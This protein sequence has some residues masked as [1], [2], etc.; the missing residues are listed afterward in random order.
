MAFSVDSLL[1]DAKVSLE[2]TAVDQ[3][4]AVVEDFGKQVGS[5]FGDLEKGI[6]SAKGGR[7]KSANSNPQRSWDA[8]SYAAH[9]AGGTD[10]RPKLKFLFKVEFIFNAEALKMINKID[11]LFVQKSKE[12]TFMIKSVDRPKIDF[13]YEEEVNMYNFRTKVLKKVR[14]RDLTVVFMDDTGNRVFD[15]F[16]I[17]MMIHSPI[18]TRQL[19]RDGTMKQPNASSLS[20]GSGMAFTGMENDNA[21]R[22]VV[23]SEFGNSIEA[24]RVK[25]IFIDPSPTEGV[26]TMLKMVSFDFMNPRIVSFDLDDLSHES[27]DVVLMTMVFD[28]DWMEMVKIG[29][30]G[31]NGNTWGDDQKNVIVSPNIT[32][33]PSDISSHKTSGGKAKAPGGN[34]AS[35]PNGPKDAAAIN[36]ALGKSNNKSNPFAD[37]LSSL[38]GRQMTNITNDA[39]NKIIPQGGGGL[40]GKLSGILGDQS[41]KL[42]APITGIIQRTANEKLTS[43][44]NGVVDYGKETFSSIKNKVIVNDSSTP[45]PDTPTAVV[46]STP[47]IIPVQPVSP[48]PIA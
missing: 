32:Q 5:V 23:N 44:A 33:A 47:A 15:F 46:S 12:C 10:Y 39:I 27:N 21:H 38:L 1:K 37:T 25:Q 17:L 26:E 11:P 3:F 8:T 24:I 42:L 30:L 48:Y 7:P 9:L 45:G 16:R 43:V 2:K 35:N 6:F 4:G 28:Y 18:T 14:H 22:Q 34:A 19:S 31:A 40:Q 13:E 36:A 20:F 41:K 29:S